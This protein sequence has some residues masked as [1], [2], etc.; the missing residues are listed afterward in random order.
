[1]GVPV[2]LVMTTTVVWVIVAVVAYFGASVVAAF[3]GR[4]AEVCPG[5]VR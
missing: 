5:A 1:M 3:S 2:G 4:L